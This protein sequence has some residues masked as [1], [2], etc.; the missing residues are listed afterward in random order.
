MGYFVTVRLEADT[1][2]NLIKEVEDYKKMYHPRG[3][4]TYKVDDGFDE[5][6]SK[7]FATMRRSKSCD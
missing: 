1:E 3:Y 2:E 5:D 4:G 6:T 7:F